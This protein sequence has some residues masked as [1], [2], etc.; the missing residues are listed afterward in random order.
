MKRILIVDDDEQIRNLLVDY[1]RHLSY[2]VLFAADGAEALKKLSQKNIDCI[3]SDLVMPDMN[4]LELLKQVRSQKF[5]S[6]K[7]K[8]PFLII[9]GYP[10]IETA[11][12]V[13][14]EGAYDYITKPLQLEDVRIKVERALHTHSLEKSIKKMTGIGW[15]IIISIPIWLILGIIFGRVWR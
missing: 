13:M 9:T 12:E 7:F 15:A 11:I 4:G 2:E 5:R 1:F 10:T 8:L 3:I 14:K 6:Q